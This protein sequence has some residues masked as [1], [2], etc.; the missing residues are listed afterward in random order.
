LEGRR[1]RIVEQAWIE[2]AALVELDSATTRLETA[3]EHHRNVV[4]KMRPP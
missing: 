3:T 1:E 4:P 2:K